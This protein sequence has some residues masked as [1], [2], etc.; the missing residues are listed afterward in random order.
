MPSH[1]G[2]T[3]FENLL[4]SVA[5]GWGGHNDAGGVSLNPAQ[6]TE[7]SY[8]VSTRK[9]DSVRGAFSKILAVPSRWVA[10]PSPSFPSLTEPTPI[11]EWP[12]PARRFLRV[13]Q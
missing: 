9:R 4:Q 12:P 8:K 11:C 6:R 3:D 7:S 2:I 13:Q 10:H 5:N 1:D